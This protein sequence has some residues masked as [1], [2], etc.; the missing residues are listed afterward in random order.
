MK[1]IERLIVVIG[2][3]ILFIVMIFIAKKL[4]ESEVKDMNNEKTKCVNC[5]KEIYIADLEK[6]CPYCSGNETNDISSK[7]NTI[8]IVLRV[9]GWLIIFISFIG[10][11]VLGH[12]FDYVIM[13]ICWISCG[14]S[15]VLFFALGEV[16]QILHDIRFLLRKERK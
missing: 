1:K 16:I 4:E 5:G 6:G 3:I 12:E 14:V 2:L 10:G 9:I 7:D 15:A 11:I 13:L 8:S